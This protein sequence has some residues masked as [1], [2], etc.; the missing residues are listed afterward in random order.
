M[1]NAKARSGERGTSPRAANKSAATLTTAFVM[2]A[3]VELPNGVTG[4]T[5][6]APRKAA[7]VLAGKPAKVRP[8]LQGYGEAFA[9]SQEVGR[10]VSFRVDVDPSG[11]A[12]VTPVEQGV[13][14]AGPHAIEETEEPDPELH[15]ALAAA[16]KR[17]QLRAAE[18]L[19]TDDM[20]SAEA[21][22]VALGTSRVTVNTKRQNGQVLGLDG[23][24][25]GFRFP[26]WQL[27]AEGR[28]YTELRTL[29]ERLG[30]AWALYRF[31]VQPHGELNGL[32]GREAL[33]RGMGKAVLAAAESVAHDF[34]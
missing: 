5:F 25:R 4:V 11:S 27:D 22:A 2:D 15:T 13:S 3:G 24:K 6:R 23:A 34:R 1:A 7:Q 32:T 29:H 12:T 21:F 31:L 9:R 28:P 10:P 33:E 20:L 8:L 30:G 19:G 16:R 26:L 17:G 14:A 18:I